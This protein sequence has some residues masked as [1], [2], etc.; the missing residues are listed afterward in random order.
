MGASTIQHTLR[1]NMN[2]AQNN[3][4]HSDPPPDL[5]KKL[6]QETCQHPHGS[7]PRQRGMTLLIRRITPKLWHTSEAYY[8]DALQQTWIYFCR[9]LCEATTGKAYDPDVATP[10]TWLNAYLKH[11]LKDFQIAENRKRATTISE[12]SLRGGDDNSLDPIARLPAPPDIPS[13]LE[14]VRAWAESD[15][16]GELKS[17]CVSKHPEVTV[18]LLILKRLPP[19]TPWKIISADYGISVGTL[20]SFYQ[21]QCL[22][23]LRAFGKSQGYL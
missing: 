7:Q 14:Q 23:R 2:S 19:E 17:T 5:L 15:P 10:V 16:D 1:Q 8:A 22:T 3:R 6:I 12:S 11:R 4:G 13:W 20:S 9:N 21:R 18:Q